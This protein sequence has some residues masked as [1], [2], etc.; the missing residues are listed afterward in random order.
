MTAY[1]ACL[2]EFGEFA[3]RKDI[4]DGGLRWV[5]LSGVAVCGAMD[6]A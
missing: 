1:L 4:Q 2:R 3:R 6:R 5:G